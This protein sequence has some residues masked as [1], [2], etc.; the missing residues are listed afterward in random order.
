MLEF[1]DKG[2]LINDVINYWEMGGGSEK[3]HF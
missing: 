3:C 1:H 2:M